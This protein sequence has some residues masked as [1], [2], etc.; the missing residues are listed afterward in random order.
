M[1]RHQ[2]SEFVAKLVV[3]CAQVK[4]GP[5]EASLADRAQAG[6]KIKEASPA[7]GAVA[8]KDKV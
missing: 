2:A 1:Q 5:W 4:I 3:L 7:Q 8:G 6:L